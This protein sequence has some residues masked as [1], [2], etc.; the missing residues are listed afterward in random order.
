[1]DISSINSDL[2]RGNVTTIILKALWSEDRYGYDI[3]REIEVKSQGQYKL[4]QP[5]L[6]SCLKRLEKQ[7]LISS[8]WGEE[9][10][11]EGGRRR[12]YSLTE[13]GRSLLTKMQSEYEYS[14]TILNKLLSEE[15]FDF[16]AQPAPFDINGLRPYTKRKS[17]DEDIGKQTD[18]EIQLEKEVIPTEISNDLKRPLSTA[19]FEQLT[20]DKT[21]NEFTSINIPENKNPEPTK[22]F[23]TEVEGSSY[24][25]KPRQTARS[26]SD[27]INQIDTA[28]HK[29][30][31]DD[32]ETSAIAN[33]NTLPI[34]DI[35]STKEAIS[36]DNKT[37]EIVEPEVIEA[38]PT[39]FPAREYYRPDKIEVV[40]KNVD[41]RPQSVID[42]EARI[43][44]DEA[45]KALGIGKY[46]ETAPLDIDKFVESQKKSEKV[47]I[48][49]QNEPQKELF[50]D[51]FS[52]IPIQQQKNAKEI[53][54][55]NSDQ[56]K[57]N[58]AFSA[59]PIIDINGATM[60][61]KNKSNVKNNEIKE[62]KE[63][64]KVEPIFEKSPVKP[65][66]TYKFR[67]DENN[68]CN[69]ID[70]FNDLRK[71][72]DNSSN[73]LDNNNFVQHPASGI[74]LK[75][76]LYG[77]GYKLRPYTREN[78]EEYYSLKYYH[79]NKLSK[80]CYCL[81]Y[82]LFLVEIFIGWLIFK[83]RFSA[84]QYV[85]FGAG[86]LPIFIIPFVIYTTRPDK[87]IRANYNF[88]TSILSRLMLYLNCVII[89]FLLGFF[90]FGADI[91]NAQSM[92]STILIPLLLL[93]NIPISSLIYLLLFNSKKYHIS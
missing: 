87:R 61:F 50:F 71:T 31:N 16:E 47:D 22:L 75:T 58:S 15:D 4:K 53:L 30:E 64:K 10:D 72:S 62:T 59:S 70:A 33:E 89:V 49:E 27:I 20:I 69:Y 68:V 77:A 43:K 13:A 52:P 1:M 76:K 21:N 54:N 38:S 9:S 11:T 83:D 44:R 79:S 65:A 74:D 40:E 91:N 42:E 56:M 92:I 26:L 93:L 41:M 32:N 60:D 7:G 66:S 85:L 84:L 78:T 81:V 86:G 2:I 12:Y 35:I 48:D 88:K 73:N 6:Y 34:T 17:E 55:L 37:V 45:R 19:V 14:R 82:L 29:K 63:T 67:N 8:Y 46:A 18:D 3:L 57:N 24:D 90:V 39:S 25:A 23:V 80:D 5:T 36:E 51:I 28:V